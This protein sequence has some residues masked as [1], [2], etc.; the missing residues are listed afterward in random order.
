MGPGPARGSEVRL[1]WAANMVFSHRD[2]NAPQQAPASPGAECWAVP[3]ESE[4][5]SE[6][7]D[8]QPPTE[9]DDSLRTAAR[10]PLRHLAELFE[11]ARLCLI[12]RVLPLDIAER[13]DHIAFSDFG[14]V[15]KL[16]ATLGALCSDLD[17]LVDVPHVRKLSFMNNLP[18]PNYAH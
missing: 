3:S 13:F 1:H 11:I 6:S 10:S 9:H 15:L 4:S 18:G 12:H 2:R 14:K 16:Q 7:L 17:H 5:E 8:C